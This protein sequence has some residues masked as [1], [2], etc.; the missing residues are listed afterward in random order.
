MVPAVSMDTKPAPAASTQQPRLRLRVTAAA[1][2]A[3]RS[4]HPWV[5]SDSIRETNRPGELGE[6][7][8]IFDR[9]DRFLAIGLYEPESP[10]TVRILHQGR[11]VPVDA[12][13]WRERLKRALAR[14]HGL[15]D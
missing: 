10:L 9:E 5:Y 4:G 6:L 14:R 1:E 8:V 2:R 12:T 15:F 13:W 7:A 3:I 11:P